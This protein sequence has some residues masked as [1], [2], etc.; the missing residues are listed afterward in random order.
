MHLIELKDG[1]LVEVDVIGNELREVSGSLSEKVDASFEQVKPIILKACRPIAN[2]YQELNQDMGVV[3]A[4]VELGLSFE[5]EG[6]LYITKS[7]VGANLIVKLI[8]K[9]S[10]KPAS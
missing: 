4:E 1:T 10:T 6:N 2:A 9:P 8:L 3:Q 7:K 5:G